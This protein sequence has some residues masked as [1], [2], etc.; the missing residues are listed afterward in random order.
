MPLSE[1]LLRVRAKY[2]LTQEQLANRL[3]VTRFYI[4]K[5]ESGKV[6]KVSKVF[7]YKIELLENGK[8]DLE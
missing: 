8:G 1:R 5:I 2:N 7:E 3:K 6:K 4:S